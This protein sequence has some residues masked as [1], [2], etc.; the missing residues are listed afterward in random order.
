MAVTEGLNPL[1]DRLEKELDDGFS[2]LTECIQGLDG[3]SEDP[4]SSPTGDAMKGPALGP[5][6][7]RIPPP[8]THSAHGVVDRES[9]IT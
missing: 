3:G 2:H 7:H 8:P 9:I 5:F 4:T 1:L 6:G